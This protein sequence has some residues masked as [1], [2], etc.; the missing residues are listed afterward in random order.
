M[1]WGSFIGLILGV[2]LLA[3]FISLLYSESSE[4]HF[5][6]YANIIIMDFN[7]AVGHSVD[8]F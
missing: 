7:R 1:D 3:F 2:Y 6:L 5:Y 4:Y 8:L